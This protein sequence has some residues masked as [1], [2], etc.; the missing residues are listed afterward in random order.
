MVMR[1]VRRRGVRHGYGTE[2]RICHGG[3]WTFNQSFI[4]LHLYQDII[5]VE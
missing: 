4:Y 1:I 2:R 5:V 3:K